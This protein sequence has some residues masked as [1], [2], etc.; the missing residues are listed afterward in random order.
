MADKDPKWLKQTFFICQLCNNGFVKKTFFKY[1]KENVD[2]KNK[3]VLAM[4][5]QPTTHHPEVKKKKTNQQI[6]IWRMQ[7]WQTKIYSLIPQ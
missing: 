3:K 5:G 6:V 2:L 4:D 1:T 7:K